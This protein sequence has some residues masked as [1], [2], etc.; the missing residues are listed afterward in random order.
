[1]P[2]TGERLESKVPELDEGY[3]EGGRGRTEGRWSSG[4]REGEGTLKR[5]KGEE[6]GVVH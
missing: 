1:M 6:K 3:A 2:S 4:R 5:E